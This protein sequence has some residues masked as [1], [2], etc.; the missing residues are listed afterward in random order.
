MKQQH[1]D[2][3]QFVA[4]RGAEIAQMMSVPS[5]RNLALSMAEQL[6]EHYN[7]AFGNEEKERTRKRADARAEMAERIAADGPALWGELHRRAMNYSGGDHR[8][9]RLWLEEFERKLACGECARFFQRFCELIP[10]NFSAFFAWSVD[11]H[12]AVNDKL[13]KKNLTHAQAYEI[14]SK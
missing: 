14:W 9:E 7:E 10:P 12:N 11:L 3:F 8:I 4:S 2:Q 6:S 5:M 13:G 1:Q